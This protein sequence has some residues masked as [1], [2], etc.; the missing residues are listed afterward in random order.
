MKKILTVDHLAE[1][2]VKFKR[3]NK[4][5]VLCHGCFDPLH[6]GHIW[7]FE[8]AKSY[9]DVLMTTVTPDCFVGKGINRPVFN[10]SL[11][12]QMISSLEIVDYT[13]INE[14]PTAVETIHKIKPDYY[15]KGPD[16]I[17]L[18]DQKL[19]AELDAVEKVGGKMVFT[20]REKFSSTELLSKLGN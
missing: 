2:S 16:Y 9:G 14:W 1:L 20:T 19:K 10:D 15:V 5:I 17:S 12:A 11:R 13:G 8:E 6:I 18:S 7:Y 3:E 4:K